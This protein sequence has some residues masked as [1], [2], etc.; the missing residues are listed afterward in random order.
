M[1]PIGKMGSKTRGDGRAA[2]T[3]QGLSELVECNTLSAYYRPK[4]RA[5][6]SVKWAALVSLS[7][8][9]PYLVGGLRS[10]QLVM[11]CIAIMVVFQIRTIC[12][13]SATAV[14]MAL[15]GAIVGVSM[16]G[17]AFPIAKPH[18][19]GSVVA[20]LDNLLMPLAALSVGAAWSC[21]TPAAR[22]E[23]LDALAEWF[24]YGLLANTVFAA[25]ATVIDV[26]SI[27]QAFWESGAVENSV[28][29]RASLLGRFGGVFNQPAEAGLAYSVGLQLAL[30][31]WAWREQRHRTLGVVIAVLCLG[32]LLSVSK[33][34]LFAGIP[35]LVVQLWVRS[36]RRGERL[37]LMLTIALGI[38]VALTTGAVEWGGSERLLALVR[39]RSFSL[40]RLTAGRLGAESS[41][42]DLASRVLTESPWAG[43]GAQGLAIPY[44][45]VAGEVLVTSGLL[46]VGLLSILVMFIVLRWIRS[47]SWLSLPERRLSLGMMIVIA[48]ASFGLP[49]FTANRVAPVLWLSLGLALIHLSPTRVARPGTAAPLPERLAVS[50]IRQRSLGI[51]RVGS[52]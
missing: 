42:G 1:T 21:R 33:V 40:E 23:I 32:G 51:G 36:P 9:G 52:S 3:D 30:W 14:V 18:L 35:A 2:V 37:G 28:A 10:D 26:S 49:V 29:S 15:W 16:I 47:R 38:L 6:S 46:G 25:V 4:R 24:V 31:R 20:G 13:T 8:F 48:G 50:N 11:Y 5:D 12:V 45:S 44:D 41:L 22:R 7:M 27:G 34:F 43:Y 17:V 39:L 19:E